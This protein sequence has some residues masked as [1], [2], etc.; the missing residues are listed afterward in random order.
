MKVQWQVKSS[1]LGRWLAGRS[2]S[3]IKFRDQFI[4]LLRFL[5]K[6]EVDILVKN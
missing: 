5:S 3:F 6:V 4:T 2:R 1:K